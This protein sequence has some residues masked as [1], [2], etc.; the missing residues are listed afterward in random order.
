[1]DLT[2]DIM[3][4][5][6]ALEA[7]I[8]G[9]KKR[10]P[11]LSSKA[12]SEI[13]E[14]FR[15]N[16]TGTKKDFLAAVKRE[17]P[18]WNTESASAA[19]DE[20]SHGGW[21]KYSPQKLELGS[22]QKRTKL[23][24]AAIGREASKQASAANV[25]AKES[26]K[27]LPPS[28]AEAGARFATLG[29]YR[30]DYGGDPMSSVPLEIGANIDAALLSG[31][32]SAGLR[33]VA[34][35]V[36][37]KLA[38][39]TAAKRALPGAARAVVGATEGIGVNALL[40][41][42][43][44]IVHGDWVEQNTNPLNLA[45]AGMMG[46]AGEVLG[47]IATRRSQA[48]A[49]AKL[50]GITP[51]APRY[52]VREI[53]ELGTEPTGVRPPTKVADQQARVRRMQEL[54]AGEAPPPPESRSAVATI[55]ERGFDGADTVPRAAPESMTPQAPKALPPRT[56][57]AAPPRGTELTPIEQREVFR[58]LSDQAGATVTETPEGTF[59]TMH[60]AGEAAQP[61]I[62][63]E[64][65]LADGRHVKVTKLSKPTT[66]V[67]AVGF[68][69]IGTG[70]TG[71]M[72]LKKWNG[73]AREPVTLSMDEWA[74]EMGYNRAPA[75]VEPPAA[76]P[77][78]QPAE[79][80]PSGS[81][82]VIQTRAS[83]VTRVA[84]D[85]VQAD[86]E[87]FQYKLDVGAEGAGPELKGVK[88]WNDALGGVLLVW[89]DPADGVTYVVNGHHRLELA[90][91]LGV[92]EID[93]RY[94]QA[95]DWKTARAMGAVANIAEGRGTAIDA[96]KF[97]R[98]TKSTPADLA[99]QGVSLKGAVAEQ[100]MALAG[101]DDKL[102]NRVVQGELSVNR[103]TIIGRDLPDPAAQRA[104]YDLI[105][106]KGKTLTDAEVSELIHFVQAAPEVQTQTATLFG[107]E[108]L[109]Q[110]LALEKARL[111]SYLKDRLAR[112]KRLFD[113]LGKERNAGEWERAGNVVNVEES[114]QL[115]ADAA[116]V[117]EV[118]DRVSFT[119]GP[120]SDAL[121]AAAERLA[122][123]EKP[124][125]VKEALY[126]DV[127][128][129]VRRTLEGTE[130]GALP[131]VQEAPGG[132]L[133]PEP[134]G[135]DASTAGPELTPTRP[136]TLEP[137]GETTV[138]GGLFG[139]GEPPAA[140][141]VP[142]VQPTP[143]TPQ[144]GASNR[145]IT[146]ERH[147]RNQARMQE[148]YR[149]ERGSGPD[150]EWFR[151]AGETALFHIENGAR[152]FADWS[153]RMVQDCGEWIKP[154][155]Q[156]LYTEALK[157]VPD[158]QR[159]TPTPEAAGGG[160]GTIAPPRP[161][162][163]GTPPPPSAPRLP[164]TGDMGTYGPYKTPHAANM[165]LAQF[166]LPED[167]QGAFTSFVEAQAGQIDAWRRGNISHAEARA[168][169]DEI[170]INIKR[171]R[172]A[173][174]G[175]AYNNAEII[176]IK[177][178]LKTTWEDTQVKRM[179]YE[180]SGAVEDKLAWLESVEN[181]RLARNVAAGASAEAGRS[182]DAC[183]IL[184]IQRKEIAGLTAS[185]KERAMNKLLD[186]LGDRSVTDRILDEF[187]AIPEGDTVKLSQWL[188]K[189]GKHTK[190]GDWVSAYQVANLLSNPTG[191][192]GDLLSTG[193]WNAIQELQRPL[194]TAIERG[195][196]AVTGRAPAMEWGA[197]LPAWKGWFEGYRIGA[198][199]AIHL[200]K[201]GMTPEQAARIEM[202]QHYEFRGL[203]KPLNYPARF[204]AAMD[205]INR[206]AAE[207]AQRHALAATQ[208][209]QE[210]LQGEGFNAR[211][212]ELT[213]APTPEILAIEK[214]H[215]D[216]VTFQATDQLVSKLQQVQNWT[217]PGDIAVIGGRQPIK[218]I[219]PFFRT[220]YN[221]NKQMT[222]LNP[223]TGPMHL[224]DPKVRNNPQVRARVLANTAVGTAATVP[225]VMH[226]LQGRITGPAP[227]TENE[228]NLFY[229]SG[230]RPY[231]VK[232]GERW[233]PYRF[234]PAPYVPVL[235]AAAAAADAIQKSGDEPDANI[236]TQLIASV[237][238]AGLDF[239]MLTGLRDLDNAISN[240]KSMA[241]KWGASFIS[242]FVPFSGLQR[243]LVGVTDPNIRDAK[244]V[245]ERLAAGI[246]GA[247]N[248]LPARVDVFGRDTKREPTGPAALW[249]YSGTKADKDPVIQECNRLGLAPSEVG[250]A[251]KIG[252]KETRLS[253]SERREAQRAVGKMTYNLL[254]NTFRSDGY[255][256]LADEQK[257][258][259]VKAVIRDAHEAA[260]ADFKRSLPSIR[261]EREYLKSNG[262]IR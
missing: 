15:N 254:R 236:A 14:W 126:K 205:V 68:E 120:V 216:Y 125:A 229:A 93:V 212:Q 222:E 246:P 226:A 137:A 241:T 5:K 204:T 197:I 245:T 101:L 203:A 136:P 121:N 85:G 190:P 175:R 2:I 65:I 116:R 142:A 247:S 130:E 45:L 183:K 138:G 118:Y 259:V 97:M 260:M 219:V 16:V 155:L 239:S 192:L 50:A 69:E 139:E 124:N 261:Q 228:R 29:I 112:D 51:D 28:A 13:A 87:R 38:G 262:L 102:F 114:R 237:G 21:E 163:T 75:T 80:T 161:T 25:R 111:S 200:I 128:E 4:G 231:S 193:M 172:S 149:T 84:T 150:G 90:K 72:P 220:V 232:I 170:G 6:P 196:A 240:P 158:P 178:T 234:A 11:E 186:N 210:G 8:M 233:V 104:L 113:P 131:G 40:S 227:A 81:T 3:T 165:N 253:N 55:R 64:Y 198:D 156:T 37:A 71:K 49:A 57:I 107:D 52:S 119:K 88:K 77:G 31:G 10:V 201:H 195:S 42:P 117:K 168:A 181:A 62:G 243:K 225:L 252:N 256:R 60:R 83:Q 89:R 194:Q 162:A 79:P 249:P 157:R 59:A 123:G 43:G 54:Q 86:P 171:L 215:G 108:W 173:R 167:A 213:K 177:D 208:A 199:N 179:A 242:G 182:L 24:D 27:K 214:A 209:I 95:S 144:R 44:G 132:G 147:Q 159:P 58:Q 91:R 151:L 235:A 9:S 26:L 1:M 133:Y 180:A 174:K 12:K 207:N 76:Q 169:A 19:Y 176:V 17:H 48:Q 244:T 94:I 30:P 61:E 46:G 250:A 53:R 82:K 189:W 251:A 32:L 191:R 185:A 166:D 230:K 34:P 47:P 154:H 141:A 103:G 20:I 217:V 92:P 148:K 153:R 73:R 257:E 127:R 56:T 70:K 66:K 224:L 109:T 105:Q 221:I 223:L 122:K 152:E 164:I 106:G 248:K 22:G 258:A 23:G 33:T 99:E 96:A 184:A 188:A 115:A 218:Y 187:N 35:K 135:P 146:L 140:G 63:G 211:V 67:Q 41:L 36:A 39:Y 18:G 100:G 98:D 143:P 160:V 238:R 110:N 145:I 78:T 7:D 206:G 74:N 202:P 134:A 255:S 129:A